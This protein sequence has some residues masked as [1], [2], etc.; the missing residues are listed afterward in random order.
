MGSF[1]RRDR[2]IRASA[3]NRFTCSGLATGHIERPDMLLLALLISSIG[4]PAALRASEFER[5]GPPV[6]PSLPSRIHIAKSKSPGRS[7]DRPRLSQRPRY[8][9]ARP[10]RWGA[11]MLPNIG[12]CNSAGGKIETPVD[13]FKVA[14]RG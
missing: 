12:A 14:W 1:L 4:M 5:G 11:M 2:K 9:A 6:A 13:N 8:C 3:G 10:I 7:S